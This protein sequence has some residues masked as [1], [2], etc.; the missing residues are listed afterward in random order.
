SRRRWHDLYRAWQA[1]GDICMTNETLEL[2]RFKILNHVPTLERIAAN[3]DILTIPPVT[4]EID[5]SN[6]CN[7][8]CWWCST[9]DTRRRIHASLERTRALEL[10]G[11]LKDYGVQSVVFKG[12]GDP[13]MV[14]WIHEA[15]RAAGHLG[16]G[17]GMNT[18][19]ARVT[20]ELRD[21]LVAHAAW[22]RFSV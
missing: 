10:L 7:S 12:G 5:P 11:E 1:R 15:V 16:L 19:G 13:T 22:V 20:P 6:A 3:E 21:E 4:V 14:P 17:I 18:N 2:S 9:A 8:A